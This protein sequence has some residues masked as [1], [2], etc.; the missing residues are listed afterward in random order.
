MH[1]LTY[2][3]SIT[4]KEIDG[5]LGRLAER[6]NQ[7]VNVDTSEPNLLLSMLVDSRLNKDK[8]NVLITNL[9][10]GGIDSVGKTHLL[11]L[12]CI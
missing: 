11:Q 5:A 2:N 7:G 4:A 9:F 12:G 6:T 3:C 1:G 10:G 8:I